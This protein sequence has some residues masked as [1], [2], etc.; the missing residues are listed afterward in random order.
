VK[1]GYP[2][3]NFRIK[4][5]LKQAVEKIAAVQ[6]L[7]VSEYM[8]QLILKELDARGLFTELIKQEIFGT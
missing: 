2:S 8:R 1:K 4:K 5:E 6:G 3:I 7:D